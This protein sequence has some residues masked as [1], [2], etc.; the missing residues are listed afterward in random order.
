M[1]NEQVILK[2]KQFMDTE[3]VKSMKF[4]GFGWSDHFDIDNNSSML[5]EHIQS[6]ILYCDFLMFSSSF[7][8]AFRK[9]YEK[10]NKNC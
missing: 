3:Q 8:N 6:L 7:T 1:F 9:K 5:I 4:L 2:S 10:N